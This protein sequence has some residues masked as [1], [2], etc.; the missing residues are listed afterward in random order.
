MPSYCPAV[1][2]VCLTWFVGCGAG[3]IEQEKEGEIADAAVEA[4]DA[5]LDQGVQPSDAGTES[6]VSDS[7]Q[8]DA[9]PAAP[10]EREVLIP[11]DG[12]VLFPAVV[13]GNP[14][15]LVVDTGAVRS[16]FSK[17]LLRNVANGVGLATI[18]FGDDIHFE[19]YEVLAGDLS[20]AE[21][22]I[23]SAIDG[24]IGQDLLQQLYFGVDY[25]RKRAI[26]A[27]NAPANAP[28]GWTEADRITLPYELV[29][30]L[31]VL[32]VD[33]EGKQAR[34]IA[35]TGSGVTILT[36][37]HVPSD[38]LDDGCKG[39]VWHTSYGSD[40]AT[41]VRIPS[42]GVGSSQVKNSWAIVVPDEHHLASLFSAIGLE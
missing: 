18:D 20:E 26:V 36:Q 9:K 23:G 1:A 41:I 4:A 3:V 17:D 19:D 30:G 42:L 21:K 40:E 32:S 7:S 25:R 35:D 12:Q 8:P 10:T 39:Y 31:P 24:L 22:H 14:A 37:S 6:S 2:F 34:L 5:P 33:I 15:Y 28:N 11:L 29:Q 13:E 38:W 27:A 16:T